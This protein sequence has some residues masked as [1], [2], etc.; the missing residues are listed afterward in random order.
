MAETVPDGS[1]EESS[2]DREFDLTLF[3]ATGFVGRLTAEHLARRIPRVARIA[4]AGRS[5]EKLERVRAELGPRAAEWSIVVADA[6]DAAQMTDLA[7][8]TRVVVTTVGPYMRYGRELI[9]A[10]AEQ[11]THYAD[12]TGEVLFVRE[13]SDTLHETAQRT[14]ALIVNSCGFDSIPSDLGV[15]NLANTIA[16]DGEGEPTSTTL[17]VTSM[18]GGLSGGTID[19]MRTQ[20]AAMT[21]NADN[22]ATVGD[23]YAL[24][25]DREKEPDFGKE[26][27]FG[28]IDA[29]QVSSTLRGRLAPFVMAPYNTRV[30][31]RS[32]ALSNYRY[33]RSFRYREAMSVGNSRL[34]PV[35]AAAVAA[36]TG[37]AG[38]AFAIKPTRTVLDRLLPKP[39]TGPSESTR[40]NGHFT[41]DIFTTTSTGA[42]Y[43]SRVAA[44]GDPGYQATSVMLGEAGLA[45]AF[46]HQL[47]PAF[48]GGVLTPAVALGTTLIDRLREEGFTFSVDRL[49]PK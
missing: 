31:R 26:G 8:R 25:P 38:A 44:K 1:I 19:S 6:S 3:G 39:G 21:E 47:L 37:L 7:R 28:L 23:P 35:F 34:S 36:G 43:R 48:E 11:G 2:D 46:D 17:V 27:D 9:R 5:A 20:I 14:G 13:A 15:L 49:D 33:G 40:V 32:N 24:S 18:R 12:L 41:I 29:E 22:R 10:C 30:V 42:H 4:L 16:A 45:L